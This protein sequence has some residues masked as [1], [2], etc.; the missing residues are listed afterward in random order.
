MN[1]DLSGYVT[2]QIET[3]SADSGRRIKATAQTLRTVAEE[4][5][6]DPTT[7][8]AADLAERGAEMI[9]RIGTYFE[10][11]DFATM[12][13]DA[14]T[15]SRQQPWVVAAAGLAAG[16][17]AS[18]LVKATAARR[19]FNTGGSSDLEITRDATTFA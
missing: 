11:T 14:E 7:N 4:L 13:S 8:P 17:L 19:N 6:N 12:V 15:F 16:I 1:I 10:E 5:R 18:R 2:K 9:D 3:R